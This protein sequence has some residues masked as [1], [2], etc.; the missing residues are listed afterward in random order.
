MAAPTETASSG[1]SAGRVS[2][3]YDR[4]DAALQGG[5]LPGSSVIISSPAGPDLPVLLRKFVTA[6]SDDNTARLIICRSLASAKALAP[7]DTE[8]MKF[9]ICEAVPSSRNVVS[10]KG[11]ANLTEINLQVS[12]LLKVGPTKR[13]V[14]EIVSD[15][16]L[17]HRALQTRKWL[18]E[19]LTRLRVNSV[20]TLAVINPYMHP[21]EDVEAVIGLFDGL[22]EISEAD[23]RGTIQNVLRIKWMNGIGVAEPEFALDVAPQIS[24][25]K[26]TKIVRA[27]F[28]NLP[29]HLTPLIGREKELGEVH[30]LLARD[31]VKLVT[32]TGPGGTG[33]TRL[34]LELAAQFA[35]CYADGVFFVSLGEI[36]DPSLLLPTVAHTLEVLEEGGRPFL[37]TL[38]DYLHDKQMLLVLDNF[39]Q[40]VA[41]APKVTQLIESCPRIKVLTTSRE[42]L[43]I[44][45]EFEFFV[46]PLPL[47]DLK[48]P[49]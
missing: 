24:K 3:G 1:P 8:K 20:T 16:L 30:G 28:R 11:V 18:S 31:D 37:N 13:V 7:I 17:Q 36:S 48:R 49:H 21:R 32:L 10:V 34:A 44:R 46:P 47:P 4:L 23:V 35:D 45:G 15:V 6:A 22:L 42:S 29:S 39:E 2:T 43:R 40:I 41:S 27:R 38:T 33:K 19:L 9:V 12:E 5:F 25:G 14:I 26:L